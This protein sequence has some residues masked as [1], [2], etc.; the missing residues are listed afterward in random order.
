M[1]RWYKTNPY[2]ESWNIHVCVWWVSSYLRVRLCVIF[3]VAENA[4]RG[5]YM[6]CFLDDGEGMDPSKSLHWIEGGLSYNC[7]WLKFSKAVSWLWM[8]R[9]GPYKMGL[10]TRQC[11]YRIILNFIIISKC[12][13]SKQVQSN[14]VTTY[15]VYNVF[16]HTTYKFQSPEF[17]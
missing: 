12:N 5:G 14:L 3:P 4:L 2:S 16:T 1:R 11:P 9:I 6:L 15:P 8:G 7:Y 13:F 17:P 10:Y